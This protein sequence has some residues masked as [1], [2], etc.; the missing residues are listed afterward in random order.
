MRKLALMLVLVSG[1]TFAADDGN[2]KA[3]KDKR[4]DHKRA[5]FEHMDADNDGAISKKEHDRALDEMVKKRREM[6]KSA[7]VNNDGKVDKD[8]AKA[9]HKA[10]KE[11]RKAKREANQNNDD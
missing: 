8:E 10:N 9:M 4:H 7:D 1:A 11:M 5:M 3:Q 6:F 2:D